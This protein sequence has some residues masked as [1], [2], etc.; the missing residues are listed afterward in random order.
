MKVLIVGAGVAG[1]AIGWRLAEAGL[2]VEILERGVA[3]R[4]ATWASAGMIAAGAEEVS[5]NHK[6]AGFALKARAEWPHFAKALEAASGQSIA[7]V[8]AGSL[9]VAEDEDR[10]RTLKAQA[11]PPDGR[12]PRW[13]PPEELRE[14]EPLLSHAL[15]G[16]LYFPDDA[17]VD[18]RALADALR[19]TVAK[20]GARLREGCEVRSLVVQDGRVR[21]VVTA[22]GMVESDTIVLACGAWMNLIGGLDPET[23]PPVKPAKG[24]MIAV[25][26]PAGISLPQ[27]PIWGDHVYLVPRK[28]RLFIG[29]T[30]EDVSFDT[31]ISRE[32]RDSLLGAA[33]RLIPTLPTWRVAE[34]WAGLRPRTPDDAPVLGATAVAGLYV[35]GGQFR[36][37]ILFAPAV[38]DILCRL[39]LNELP[40]PE[41]SPF[42]PRRFTVS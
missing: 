14:R 4:G 17:Q 27:S 30:V 10:G 39:I 41:A 7:Y 22:D 18:N 28:N 12:A 37:G 29:A 34:M 15:L 21:A 11:A 16:G 36:N 8:E 38:A 35:A 5:E 24:Q 3:G 9:L 40:H 42:D 1:L 6:M 33:T 31:S 26:P 19:T 25:E 13:L 32:A 20:S 23:L 2:G